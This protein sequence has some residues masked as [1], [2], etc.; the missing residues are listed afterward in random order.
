M[1][2]NDLFDDQFRLLQ[3]FMDAID[4]VAFVK[5]LTGTYKFVNQSFCNQFNVRKEQVIGCS[6]YF[7]FPADVA[8]ALQENDLEIIKSLKPLAVEES[9]NNNNGDLMVYR[10]EKAPIFDMNGEVAGLCGIGF[11]IT[12]KRR[13]EEENERLFKKVGE[14]SL[15]KS[16]VFEV[17]S[18]DFRTPLNWIIGYMDIL[19]D[20]NLELEEDKRL[21]LARTIHTESKNTLGMLDNLLEWSRSHIHGVACKPEGVD[22]GV[23]LDEAVGPYI[24]GAHK[25]G[26][27]VDKNIRTGITITLDNRSMLI[28][29]GNIFNNAIK[30]TASGG[31]IVLST[32]IEG[33]DAIISI[34]DTGVGIEKENLSKI[35]SE[36]SQYST[37][38]TNAEKGTGIGMKLCYELVGASGG[39]IEVDSVVGK[40]TTFKILFG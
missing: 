4:G 36:S 27:A 2:V 32:Y 34:A 12:V 21:D 20:E 17:I 19:F 15:L 13:L 5:D 14:E 9:G 39:R 11:D 31:K 6:D 26:I 25:K 29:I 22:L 16:K 33:N 8:A 28:A 38:G 30:F 7:V 1:D 23:L 24:D 3:S 35:F 18:H 40:G 10:T 37:L